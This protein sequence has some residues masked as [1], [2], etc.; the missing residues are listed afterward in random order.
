MC[1]SCLFKLFEEKTAIR[2]PMCRAATDHAYVVGL[3]DNDKYVWLADNDVAIV[4]NRDA[5]VACVQTLPKAVNEKAQW[6]GENTQIG[7]RT[8]E[9]GELLYMAAGTC[10][11][12]F[13]ELFNKKPLFARSSMIGNVDERQQRREH[14]ELAKSLIAFVTL[15]G[16]ED[17]RHFLQMYQFPLQLVEVPMD[18]DGA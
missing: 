9:D 7:V 13:V 6:L 8:T 15:D 5:E 11:A 10:T 14:R 3:H 18:A 17:F 12:H 16:L 2:C 1:D 4:G